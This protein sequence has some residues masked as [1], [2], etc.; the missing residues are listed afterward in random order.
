MRVLLQRVRQA[1]VTVEGETVGAIGRGYLLLVGI[2]AGDSEEE[3]QML[4]AKIAHLRLFADDA[5]QMNRSALDLLATGDE[6]GM[7]VVSQFTLY[8]DV[9]KGR[10][11]S[12]TRAA[13]PAAAAPL[14]TR[15][16]AEL[17]AFGLP[18]AEGRFGATMAVASI[19]DGPV[20][21]WLDSTDLRRAVPT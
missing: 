13:P 4:A 21:V 19:N 5:G 2:A 7:L 18:V 3:G 16:A 14:V 8:A 1:A 20:T 15:F 9:R 17:R 12:F 6:V 10:R 11:P